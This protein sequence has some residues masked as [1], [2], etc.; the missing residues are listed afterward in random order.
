MQF[1]SIF[2]DQPPQH[3][4]PNKTSNI[5]S[6]LRSFY[7]VC[8]LFTHTLIIIEIIIPEANEQ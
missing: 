4:Y 3:F 7:I 8:L 5:L 1:I 2:F 6:L